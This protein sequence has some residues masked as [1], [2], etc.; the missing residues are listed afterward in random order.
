MWFIGLGRTHQIVL[1][2]LDQGADYFYVTKCSQFFQGIINGSWWQN[3]GL[4]K[5]L[6]SE[7]VKLCTSWLYFRGVLGL[8]RGTSWT[9]SDSSSY[10]STLTTRIRHHSWCSWLV[11]KKNVGFKNSE[12]DISQYISL[13]PDSFPDSF[14]RTDPCVQQQ[15]RE[16]WRERDK[17]LVL[18]CPVG[19]HCSKGSF[20]HTWF[21]FKDKSHFPLK[22][23]E[24]PSTYSLEGASLRIKSL[25]FSDSG[26]YYCASVRSGKRAKDSQHVGLGTALTVT[27]KR[28]TLKVPP[29]CLYAWLR[30]ITDNFPFAFSTF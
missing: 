26:I 24:I 13:F 22:P 9:E 11:S 15:H 8:G 4:Q 17:Q 5:G 27:R 25:N 20:T 16:I 23:N 18:R 21:V 1:L 10:Y 2:I 3:S 12:F 29:R 14:K 7:Y 28:R 19:S 6:I 30:W